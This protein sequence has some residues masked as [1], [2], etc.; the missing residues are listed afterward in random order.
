MKLIIGIVNEEDSRRLEKK[1][2][3]NDI[4]VTKLASTGGFLRSGNVTFL[5]GVEESQVDLTL[6]IYEQTC[7][8]R[9][10]KQLPPSGNR[11]DFS[12]EFGFTQPVDVEV[13]GAV[14][15]IL[16]VDQFHKI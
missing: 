1:L 13:G 10:L 4:R 9:T 5:S 11:F 12:M 7:S 14:V 15:F 8:K 6:Q 3:E 16:D 2:V